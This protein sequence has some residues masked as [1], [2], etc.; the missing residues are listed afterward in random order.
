MSC[1]CWYHGPVLST[2]GWRFA[3]ETL[4]DR[5]CESGTRNHKT[6]PLAEGAC[7]GGLS[8]QGAREWKITITTVDYQYRVSSIR[9]KPKIDV[10]VG[11][12]AWQDLISSIPPVGIFGVGHHNCSVVS[13][14]TIYL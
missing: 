12:F 6:L 4:N 5:R 2:R 13:P 11:D 7:L 9:I 1:L 8:F 10:V 14:S 3:R